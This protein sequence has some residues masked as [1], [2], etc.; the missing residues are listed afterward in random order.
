N[1]ILRFTL[2][3]LLI[4]WC[5]HP[6][7]FLWHGATMTKPTKKRRPQATAGRGSDKFILR[8][9]EGMRVRLALLA[10]GNGRSMN[11]EVIAALEK[12]FENDDAIA[13][14]WNKVE[15]L[16]SKVRD[17]DEQLNTHLD[18]ND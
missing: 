7:T 9:P 18:E 14:L 11:A 6:A 5:H 2:T 8:L 17:H 15:K 4:S 3:S 10:K 12:H 13:E 16:E 1:I